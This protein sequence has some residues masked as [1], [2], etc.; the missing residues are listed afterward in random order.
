MRNSTGKRL[1]A[2][3]KKKKLR[4][5]AKRRSSY[6]VS[7]ASTKESRKKSETSVVLKLSN[8]VMNVRRNKKSGKSNALR[9]SKDAMK[10]R[11]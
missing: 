6:S 7:N 11:G 4:E 8:A 9:R 5:T 10:R 1:R 2:A 3:N